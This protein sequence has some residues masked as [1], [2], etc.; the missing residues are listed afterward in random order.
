MAALEVAGW[1]VLR[2]SDPGV[3]DLACVRHGVTV[4]LEIKSPG[5]AMEPGQPELHRRMEAAGAVVP[6]VTSPEEALR[7]VKWAARGSD[8]V[9][10]LT[11]PI[12]TWRDF[13]VKGAK[14]PR[15]VSKPALRIPRH[16]T[17]VT[18]KKPTNGA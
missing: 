18:K 1:A 9:A 5:G 13:P 8:W 11:D 6:V 7:A 14:K 16:L 2:L 10:C 17:T 3:P 15:R 4:W 12:A